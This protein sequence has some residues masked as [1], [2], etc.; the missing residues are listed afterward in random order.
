VADRSAMALEAAAQAEAAEWA[1]AEMAV[2]ED[3]IEA[4]KQGKLQEMSMLF[5]LY[6]P[7]W[8]RDIVQGADW[9]NRLSSCFL[10]CVP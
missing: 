9:P 6:S 1:A 2:L 3:E 7:D 10:M 8:A 5:P 4:W